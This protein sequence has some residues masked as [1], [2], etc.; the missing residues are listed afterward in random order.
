MLDFL[1]TTCANFDASVFRA[2]NRL[3]VSAGGFF[4]PFF[5]AITFVGEWGAIVFI[6][7]FILMLFKKTRKLGVCMFGAVACGALITNI[8]IKDIVARKRPFEL[9]EEFAGFLK[10]IGGKAEMGYSFPSGHVTAVAGSMTGLFIICN[11]KFSW[12][13]VFAVL[14]MGL[15]RVY[16]IAHYATDVIAGIV[17]GMIS[18]VISYF[19][20]KLIY[21]L[22][23]KY[24]DKKFFN[25]VLNF[26]IL[27]AFKR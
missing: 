16:L 15:S 8:T 21:H 7:A 25:F 6:T 22:L 23:N 1:N 13:G 3:A 9:S 17:V 10:F 27:E 19:I 20:T 5:K 24:Q 11:K 4:T 2:M 12:L 26:D 14:L 18:G